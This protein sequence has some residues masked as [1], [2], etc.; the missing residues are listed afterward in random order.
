MHAL[1]GGRDMCVQE[2]LQCWCIDVNIIMLPHLHQCTEL[3]VICAGMSYLLWHALAVIGDV[4]LC[5]YV[6]DIYATLCYTLSF[7]SPVL[8]DLINLCELS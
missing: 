1:R 4:C 6:N 3:V 2:S 5:W 7:C 8:A